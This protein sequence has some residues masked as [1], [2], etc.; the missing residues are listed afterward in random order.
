MTRQDK[1]EV[2]HDDDGREGGIGGNQ[3]RP[4]KD[5]TIKTHQGV[6]DRIGTRR[7]EWLL[8]ERERWEM[9]NRAFEVNNTIRR[10]DTKKTETRVEKEG[11]E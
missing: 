4:G 8:R 2:E 11:V 9:K 1:T 6:G 5:N 3:K 7:R 10:K